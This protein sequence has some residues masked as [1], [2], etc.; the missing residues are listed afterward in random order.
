MTGVGEVQGSRKSGES[1]G[2][3]EDLDTDILV[4]I[5]MGVEIGGP[6]G[7]LILR[8]FNMRWRR[9]VSNQKGHAARTIENSP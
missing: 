1:I 7:R 6:D 4:S 5:V 8:I 9:T 2:H 3:L